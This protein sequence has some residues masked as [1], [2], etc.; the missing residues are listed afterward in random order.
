MQATAL[1][2]TAQVAERLVTA[3][4]LMP[5]HPVFSSDRRF[6]MAGVPES[7]EALIWPAHYVADPQSRIVLMTWARCRATGESV[8]DRYRGLG[9]PR[10]VAERRRRDALAQ[11]AS[12]LNE[13]LTA[14]PVD[15]G[16]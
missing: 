13:G 9:W 3:F 15:L 10:T 14:D 5:Y 4:R 1:W 12:G 2:T 11:I 8:R 7:G 6:A 16:P